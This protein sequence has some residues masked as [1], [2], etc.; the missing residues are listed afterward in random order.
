MST[1]VIA[2]FKAKDEMFEKLKEAFKGV[3]TETKNYDGC[4]QLG[5]C[6]DE[7]DKSVILYEV[8][9]SADH[10]KKYLE[11]REDTGVLKAIDEMCREAP[12][13]SYKSFLFQ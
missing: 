7:N 12:D 3:L 5:A 1:S 2:V 4:Q 13:I 11:W 8:W 10:H 6:S 9:D